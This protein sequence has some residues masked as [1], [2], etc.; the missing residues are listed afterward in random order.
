MIIRNFILAVSIFFI[1]NNL[2][3]HDKKEI[4]QD[5]KR[6]S[7]VSSWKWGNDANAIRAEIERILKYYGYPKV[8]AL[9]QVLDPSTGLVT[10]TMIYTIQ[11]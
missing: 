9:T 2:M 6:L 10:T 4:N 8:E 11:E 7:Y 5:K 1:S 3:A